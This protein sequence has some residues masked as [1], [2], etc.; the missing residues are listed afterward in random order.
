M[1]RSME[2]NS[3]EEQEEQKLGSTPDLSTGLVDMN[4][5]VINGSNLTLDK[6]GGVKEKRGRRD[7]HGE[8]NSSTA[9][10]TKAK[11]SSTSQLSVA[12]KFRKENN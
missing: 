4:N 10:L 9:N 8:L 2:Q 11:S 6:V 5:N 7:K 3:I 1:T 12:G